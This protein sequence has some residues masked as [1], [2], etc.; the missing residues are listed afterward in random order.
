MCCQCLAVTAYLECASRI[1]VCCWWLQNQ[2]FG[3]QTKESRRPAHCVALVE[4]INFEY[5]G[6]PNGAV[7]AELKPFEVLRVQKGV[8]WWVRRGRAAGWGIPH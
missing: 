7:L 3:S 2:V 4:L 5:G 6:S 1:R 8:G